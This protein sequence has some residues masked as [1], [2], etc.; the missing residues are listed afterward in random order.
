MNIE[1]QENWSKSRWRHFPVQQQPEYCDVAMLECVENRLRMLPPLIFASE[2]QTLKSELQEAM[3]GKGFVFQ[4][5]DCA[6]S[7]DDLNAEIIKSSLQLALKSALI[8][9]FGIEQPVVKIMR[10]AGQYAKPRSENFEERDGQ[11]LPIY[12]GDMINDL[13]FDERN[14]IPDPERMIQAYFHSAATHNLLR[15]FCS[16]GFASLDNIN[17][18][19]KDFLVRHRS[20][21][22]YKTIITDINS[23]IGNFSVLGKDFR[24]IEESLVDK[25]AIYTSHEALLLNYEEALT[26][27]DSISG[28]ELNCSAHMLWLGERTRCSK[29]AHVDYLSGIDNPI[30]IKV[31]PGFDSDDLV[32]IIDKINP[33][34]EPGKIVLI[35]RFGKSQVDAYLPSLIKTIQLEGRKVLWMCDPMH[36]NTEVLSSGIKTRKFVNILAETKRFFD[37]HQSYGTHPG[38]LH[39]EMTG[40]DVAECLGGVIGVVEADVENGY[41]SKCDPRLNAEQMLELSFELVERMRNL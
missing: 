3:E 30:G 26:R 37:I 5:G 7:F 14:R 18:W 2:V 29:N 34:N 1:F 10:M 38:G 36:G 27:T 21:D 16:E 28:V 20:K 11:K 25:S 17:E 9:S 24:T 19:N 41:Q 15:A 40:S 31:G 23:M 32:R 35:T 8:I 13:A 12:R 39:I 4:G 33:L 22:R 6:E